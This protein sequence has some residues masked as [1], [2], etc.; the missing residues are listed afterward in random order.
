MSLCILTVVGNLGRDPE[1]RDVDGSTVTSFRLAH[2]T[3]IKGD[4]QTYW[5]GVDAWGK[6]GEV[7]AQYL[8]KG[9]QVA[10]SGQFRPREYTDKDGA[11]R[12]SLDIRATDIHFVGKKGDNGGGSRSSGSSAARSDPDDDIPF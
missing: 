7:C 4:E 11:T 3:K 9:S 1:S 6:L 12:T 8:E 2:S 5:F 10:V